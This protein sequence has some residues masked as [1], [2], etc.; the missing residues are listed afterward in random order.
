[1][2]KLSDCPSKTIHPF[3]CSNGISEF[4][5]GTVLLQINSTALSFF[6][7]AKYDQVIKF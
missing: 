2:A 4:F 7:V 3:F 5:M 6:F 1:M